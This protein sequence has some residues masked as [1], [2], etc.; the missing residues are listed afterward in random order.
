MSTPPFAEVEADAH[1]FF[2]SN[3]ENAPIRQR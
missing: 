3:K 1:A 2:D